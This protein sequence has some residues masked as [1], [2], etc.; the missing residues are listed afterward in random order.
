MF[1]KPSLLSQEVVEY[2]TIRRRD[3]GIPGNLTPNEWYVMDCLW[4]MGQCTGREAVEHLQKSVGWSRS[5]TLTMLRRMTE[6]GMIACK[7]EAGLL[8]YSPLV[9]RADATQ[10][11]TD[12]FLSR[13]Y[14]GSV[15]MLFSA[16]AQKQKLSQQEL[17]E[18]YAILK[19]A[20]RRD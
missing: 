11:E 17:D 9:D 12:S 14:H 3:V 13:V 16:I 1:L 8:V 2:Q 7:E 15:S 6:K 5:T 19:E 18:L 20:E 4:N 10:R